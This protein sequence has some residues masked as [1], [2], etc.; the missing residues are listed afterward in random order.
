MEN[1][2]TVVID[3]RPA[4]MTGEEVFTAYHT[5]GDLVEDL[6]YL[7]LK[8]A[9]GTP[10]QQKA[11]TSTRN[12]CRIIQDLDL[13]ANMSKHEKLKQELS[14]LADIMEFVPVAKRADALAKVRDKF[15]TMRPDII[16]VQKQLGRVLI[17][18][19]LGKK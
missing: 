2:Y 5:I 7:L 3:G 8:Q 12:V 16:D 11:R 17:D 4:E 9:V 18:L 1:N 15:M 10:A 14:E 13:L 19:E 6:T